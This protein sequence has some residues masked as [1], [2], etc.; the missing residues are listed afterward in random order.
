MTFMKGI[1]G[2]FIAVCVFGADAGAQQPAP[3]GSLRLADLQEAAVASD[4]RFAS[5]KLQQAQSD[6]RMGVIGAERRP[7]FAIEGLAQYQSDVPMPAPFLPGGT[8]LF[9]PPKD[10][11]DAYVRIDQ[12]LFDPSIGPRVELERAQLAESQARLRVALYSLRQEVNAA[13]F[14]AALLEA[15][16]GALAAAIDALEGRL[17]ETAARVAAGAALAADAAAIEATLLERRQEAVTLRANRAAA[18]SRLVRL[19][20]RSIPENASLELPELRSRVAQARTSVQTTR[21]RPE[22]TQYA[23]SRDRVARQQDSVAAQTQL[24]MSA[25]ARVGYGHPG[26][27]FIAD[28]FQLYGIAGV[29]LQWKP[30]NWSSETRE[31]EALAL[32]AQIIAA[33]EAAFTNALER[34]TDTDLRSIDRLD[35]TLAL[36]DRIVALREQ[37]ERTMDIRFRENVVTAAEYL[38]R[39]SELLNAR[40]TQAAHRVEFA[41]A[42]AR[43][44]TSLGLEVR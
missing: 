32:Q 29:Q 5:L 12:R 4:P 36:D 13:F 21:A 18:L 8:P 3:S 16:T 44:L 25:F 1:G 30:W 23:S 24:R 35:E 9:V 42:G 11:Y 40:F 43:L 20:G 2:A 27:N 14:S 15:R 17:R 10:T 41:E 33:D 22:Y 39:N 19:T 34:T 28:E 7:S 37:I 6:L 38:D 31:R 26:L